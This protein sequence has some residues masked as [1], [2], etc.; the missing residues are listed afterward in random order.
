M[1]VFNLDGQLYPT[2][3]NKQCTVQFGEHFQIIVLFS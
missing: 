3:D 2:W 1:Y